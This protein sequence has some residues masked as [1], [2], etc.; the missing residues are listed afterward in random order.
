LKNT[1]YRSQANPGSVGD[2]LYRLIKTFGNVEHFKLGQI[3]SRCV[4]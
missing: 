2:E 4:S 3:Q 1:F